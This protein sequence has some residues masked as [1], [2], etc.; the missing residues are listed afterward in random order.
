MFF[1]P[2]STIFRFDFPF[3]QY[4]VEAH[5]GNAEG[6]CF[7]IDQSKACECS[8]HG[9]RWHKEEIR[10]PILLHKFRIGNLSAERYTVFQ[11]FFMD[12]EFQSLYV[13]IAP[14][15]ADDREVKRSSVCFFVE[16]TGFD[17]FSYA[18]R[19]FYASDVEYM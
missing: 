19:R 13:M 6:F 14:E 7:Q 8:V 16:C 9:D 10:L 5:G 4:P 17:G 12:E 3:I 11:I 1:R 2:F 18:L 15:G